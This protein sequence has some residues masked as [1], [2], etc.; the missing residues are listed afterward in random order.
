MRL[1]A[2]RA[3]ACALVVLSFAW[4]AEAH[5]APSA[6]SPTAAA[7]GETSQV[8]PADEKAM[9]EIKVVKPSGTAGAT[10]STT[11]GRPI[12]HGEKVPEALRGQMK[13]MMDSA[14]RP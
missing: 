4:V 2:G 9:A 10:E 14:D 1:R 7:A 6:A 12:I 13:A 11:K 3:S 5:A 8:K